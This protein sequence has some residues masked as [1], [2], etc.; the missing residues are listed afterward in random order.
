MSFSTQSLVLVQSTNSKY[1][2]QQVIK[3]QNCTV[4]LLI[5]KYQK[6]PTDASNSKENSKAQAM[7]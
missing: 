7:I 6:A 2:I 4:K 1:I 5:D 3:N